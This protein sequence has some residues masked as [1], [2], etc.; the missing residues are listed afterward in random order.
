MNKSNSNIPTDTDAY[1]DA[2]ASQE[3]IYLEKTEEELRV[4]FTSGD[5]SPHKGNR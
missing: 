4:F 3:E 2:V 5:L 1:Y